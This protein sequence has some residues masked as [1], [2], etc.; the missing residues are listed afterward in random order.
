M[1]GIHTQRIF[2][3][4]RDRQRRRDQDHR[5]GKQPMPQQAVE[6]IWRLF[7]AIHLPSRI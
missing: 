7:R 1:Q 4:L 3:N 6:Q 5:H 2:V